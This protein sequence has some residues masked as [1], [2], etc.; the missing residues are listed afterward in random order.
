MIE[1]TELP[2]SPLRPLFWFSLFGFLQRATALLLLPLYLH[3]FSAEE[4]AVFFLVTMTAQFV[5]TFANLKLDAAMR[6]FYFDY[7]PNSSDLRNYLAQIFS[8]SLCIVASFYMLMLLIGAPL[9]ALIFS[10]DQITY[11]PYGAIAVATVCANLCL[12]PYLIFLKNQLHLREL[13]AWQAALL[14]GSVGIQVV[15][16]AGYELGVLGAL[17]GAM[18]PPFFVLGIMV[19]RRSGLITTSLQW[20]TI[21]ASLVYSLPLV[22]FGFFYLLEA[23]LDRYVLERF[24]DLLSVAK[25]G[26]LVALLGLLVTLQDALENAIRP[27]LYTK[28]GSDT[29]TA[30]RATATYATFYSLVC[31]LGLSIIVFLGSSLSVIT[32]KDDYL[33]L[34]SLVPLGAVAMIPGIYTRYSALFYVYFKK[35]KSLTTWMFLRVGVTL[36]LLLLLVPDHGIEGALVALLVSQLLNAAAFRLHLAKLRLAAIPIVKPAI[37]AAIFVGSMELCRYAFYARSPEIFG[38]SQLILCT[39]LLYLANRKTVSELMNRISTKSN[40][41]ETS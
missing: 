18:L 7:D 36:V 16:I 31:L 19:L 39:L 22:L 11:F 33:A 38:L 34:R 10:H 37:Q 25:Y 35:S 24:Y 27:F 14:I 15:L 40:P 29:E 30:A 20:P 8:A 5:G 28:L 17:I 12:S 13:I 9:Y 4:V 26:I 32:S 3:Y 2:D 23:R 6:V 1:K 41:L 21:R